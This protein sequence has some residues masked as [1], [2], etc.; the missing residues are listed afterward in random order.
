MHSIYTVHAMLQMA[1][2]YIALC[3]TVC[4]ILVTFLSLQSR[5]MAPLH[6]GHQLYSYTCANI[7][8]SLMA[9]SQNIKGAPARKLYYCARSHSVI[10]AQYSRAVGTLHAHAR[11]FNVCVCCESANDVTF[12]LQL[13]A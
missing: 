3:H 4:G 11:G 2:Y 5:L 8:T 7:R 13:I 6:D 1:L 9:C 12:A 10:I